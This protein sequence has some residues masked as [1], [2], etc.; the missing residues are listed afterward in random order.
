MLRF[1]FAICALVFFSQNSFAK[2]CDSQAISRALQE[3]Q[4]S[5]LADPYILTSYQVM[6][7]SVEKDSLFT[8]IRMIDS[9]H[10][11]FYII[12][13]NPANCKIRRVH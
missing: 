12:E 6:G 8:V 9:N 2:N 4:Q 5:G 7:R 3:H 13:Q 10:A 1:V 11:T